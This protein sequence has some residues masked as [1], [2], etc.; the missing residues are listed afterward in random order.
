WKH[1]TYGQVD[2]TGSKVFGWWTMQYAFADIYDP[3]KVK[4]LTRFEWVAEARRLAKLN[5]VDLAPFHALIAVINGMGDGSSVGLGGDYAMP[6]M[7]TWGESGWRWCSKCQTMAFGTHT[8]PGIC[9]AGKNHDHSASGQ[10]LLADNLSTFPGQQGWRRCSKCEAL[11]FAATGSSSV[12]PV[13]GSH[14]GTAS[15]SY[16]LPHGDHPF[17]GQ[18]GWR[19]CKK[20]GVLAFS[21]TQAGSCAAG[22]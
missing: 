10:Y 7:G 22:G 18:A 12:C 5:G 19:L 1:V 11:F 4:K 9:P 14:D 20:C 13:S 2:L 8:L 21:T 6:S 15:A 16:T 17:P 3:A